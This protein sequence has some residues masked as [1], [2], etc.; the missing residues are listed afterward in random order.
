MTGFR[1]AIPPERRV[2]HVTATDGSFDVTYEEELLQDLAIETYAM[3]LREVKPILALIPSEMRAINHAAYDLFNARGRTGVRGVG[4]IC[5][6][7]KI[8]P[9]DESGRVP[10][11]EMVAMEVVQVNAK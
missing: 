9:V 5:R 4:E 6:R 7:L 1:W 8:E 2:L 3:R 10:L 11:F